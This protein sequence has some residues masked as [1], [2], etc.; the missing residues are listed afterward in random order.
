ML[1]AIN[2]DI[3]AIL[4]DLQVLEGIMEVESDFFAE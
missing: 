4:L 1:Y 3:L 2:V